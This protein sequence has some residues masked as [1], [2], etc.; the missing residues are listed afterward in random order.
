MRR[1]HL[2]A[3]PFSVRSRSQT[4]DGRELAGLNDHRALGSRPKGDRGRTGAWS[5]CSSGDSVFDNAFKSLREGLDGGHVLVKATIHKTHATAD[6]LGLPIRT[7]F[8]RPVSRHPDAAPRPRANRSHPPTRVP[9]L[10]AKPTGSTRLSFRQNAALPP[11]GRK[12][13][14]GERQQDRPWMESQDGIIKTPFGQLAEAGSDTPIRSIG[15][16]HDVALLESIIG[17][18][19][20]GAIK[21]LG[22]WKP[23]R[24][25]EQQTLKWVTP[26]ACTAPSDR[27]RHKK[28]P[29]RRAS[30]DR[31]NLSRFHG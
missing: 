12:E 11:P 13:H 27:S 22:P 7:A 28:P 23:V 15:T 16:S 3:N 19:K 31:N 9:V 30:R 18:F 2:G 4:E 26:N 24:Q 10:L 29:L 14:G 20:T 6:A 17:R 25:V 5:M 1:L 21:V 8:P